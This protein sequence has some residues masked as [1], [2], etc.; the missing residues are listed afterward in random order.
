MARNRGGVYTVAEL[1]G[2]VLHRPVAAFWLILYFARQLIPLLALGD[3]IDVPTEQLQKLQDSVKT[4]PE[5]ED[6]VSR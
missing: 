2:A 4:D 1:D 3:F 6:W 5:D